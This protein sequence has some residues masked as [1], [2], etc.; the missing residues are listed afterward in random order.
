[1]VA[2]GL[3]RPVSIAKIWRSTVWA[4]KAVPPTLQELAIGQRPIAGQA[5]KAPPCG[6]RIRAALLAAD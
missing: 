2:N 6:R 4:L 1:M 3:F 5:R